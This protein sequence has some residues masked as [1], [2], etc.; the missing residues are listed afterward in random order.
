LDPSAPNATSAARAVGGLALIVPCHDEAAVVERRLA[1]LLACAWPDGPARIVVVDDHSGDG[2]L[3]RARAF[4]AARAGDRPAIDLVANDREPG[5]TSALAAGLA[6]IAALPLDERPDLVGMTDADVVLAND[7][8]VRVAAAFADPRLGLACGA[9]HFVARLADDGSP[10][11]VGAPD[12]GGRYDRITAA[13]RRLESRAG[14]LFS[15]HGQLAVW[16]RAL[17]LAP[18]IGV[19]ADDV[20]LMAQVRVAGYRT[21]LVEGATFFETKPA[22]AP[23]REGQ[24]RRRAAA[25]FD[26]LDAAAARSRAAGA[27]APLGPGLLDRAQWRVYAAAPLACARLAAPLG[28]A[29][30]AVG[31]VAVQRTSGTPAA[32]ASLGLVLLLL[33]FARGPLRDWLALARIIRAARKEGRRTLGAGDRWEM[34]RR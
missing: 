20:D 33:W 19:A 31:L 13:V 29:L 25:W 26:A 8:L 34:A 18:T 4:A 16:R 32:L 2:T 17:D 10:P 12:A 14:R 7:A 21:Q 3:E 5:K 27:P 24:A 1:N 15:V 23:D 11:P 6:R 28:V 30:V 9:Q 22:A